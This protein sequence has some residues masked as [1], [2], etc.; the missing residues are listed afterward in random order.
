MDIDEMTAAFEKHSHEAYCA[1]KTLTN[2]RSA[3]PD[4]H[5]FLLLEE[6]LPNKNFDMIAAAEHD[7]IWLD[8][9]LED[10]A[11][12]V[13]DEQVRELAICGVFIDDTESL[14]LFV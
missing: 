6:L 10:L 14:S 4:L 12:V 13:T 11:A 3:R 5:A 8:V 2:K 7:Q 1:F 9:Q